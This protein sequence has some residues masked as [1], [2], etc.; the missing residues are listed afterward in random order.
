MILTGEQEKIVGSRMITE[1]QRK[2]MSGRGIERL[3]AVL[4]WA[5]DFLPNVK[6][7]GIPLPKWAIKIAVHKTVEKIHKVWVKRNGKCWIETPV[8]VLI[9]QIS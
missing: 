8:P 3:E 5:I 4:D 6:L 1:E 9:A 7:F 2:P